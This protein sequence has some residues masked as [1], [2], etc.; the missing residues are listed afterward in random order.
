MYQITSAVA[1]IPLIIAQI[2][3]D[4]F[5][6]IT[7]GIS[8]SAI[9]ELDPVDH[10]ID[11]LALDKLFAGETYGRLKVVRFLIDGSEANFEATAEG[12]RDRL[13]GCKRKDLLRFVVR[14]DEGG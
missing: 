14:V 11:W 7:F 5:E 3:P 6:E 8:L 13:P 4:H 9:Q 12:L 1:Y 2:P 10:P